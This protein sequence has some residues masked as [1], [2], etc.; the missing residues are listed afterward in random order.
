MQFDEIDH[1]EIVF[2]RAYG[3]GGLR[4]RPASN[5]TAMA[6]TPTAR[7]VGRELRQ[8]PRHRDVDQRKNRQQIALKPRAAQ[9]ADQ[10]HMR[11]R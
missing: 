10:Q 2:V 7:H 9:Q 6:E 11:R 3:N 4:N 1:G 5:P 8:T